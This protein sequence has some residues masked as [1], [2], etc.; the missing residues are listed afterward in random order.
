MKGLKH[1]THI[2]IL[3]LFAGVGGTAR[4]IQSFLIEKQIPFTYVAIDS[5]LET[6][7]AHVINNPLSQ[8][9]CSD[10]LYFLKKYYS[11]FD[12]IW[13]SPPCQTHSR[14]NF[15]KKW[16]STPDDTLWK[17]ISFLKSIN[18]SFVVEN[19]RP[20]YEPLIKPT[21]II[22]RHCFWSDIP[23]VFFD[24]P[25]KPKPFNFMELKDWETYHGLKSVNKTYMEKRQS[26]R[27]VVNPLLARGVFKQVYSPIQATL[28]TFF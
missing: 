1:L 7:K 14:L 27:N 8:V 21:I 10:A 4:G 2:S 19:V 9:I 12:F 11:Y 16:H 26:L 6:C 5:D 28:T 22:D 13:A 17:T 24:V 23:L 3:D 25:K 15:L 18:I 20:Y